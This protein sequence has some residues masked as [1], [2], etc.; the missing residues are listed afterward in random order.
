VRA[1]LLVLAIAACG[2]HRGAP[3][4]RGIRL[5]H[6]FGARESELLGGTL[7]GWPVPVSTSLVPFARGQTV[8]GALLR[9]G[10]DCPDLIRVDATWLPALVRAELVAPAPPEAARRDWL[11]EARALAQ[12]G[13][14]GDPTMYGVPQ[15]VDGL[16][17]VLGPAAAA[18]RG[19][20]PATIDELV[21]YAHDA[22]AAGARW[23]LGLRVDGY[24]VVPFLRAAGADVADG[25]TGALGIDN[26]RASAAV[27]RFAS[28]FGSVAAPAPAPGQEADDEARRF[29]AGEIALLVTGPWALADAGPLDALRVW[30][31]PGAPRGGQLFVVP[32][33]AADAAR[34][35]QLAL[36]L[37]EPDVQLAWAR[38]IG[39]VPTTATAMASAPR[40]VR[41]AYA[42]LRGA[43]PLPRD[44]ATA[45]LFDDLTPA[46][47]AVVAGDASAD[48]A[49]AGVAR[50]WKRLLAG[51]RT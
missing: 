3:P 34:A 28:L 43:K 19:P 5:L 49:L 17:V 44:P 29:Q 18:L 36:H 12:A 50:A 22:Q 31:M 40:V 48:E 21:R 16:V 41:E 7:A 10:T 8:I 4:E 6:T 32:R 1:L 46:V 39:T 27:A 30:P 38:A 15:T 42:A 23:G 35:W 26:D 14:A 37:T 20:P 51:A 11:P 9:A 24:W 25:S 2:G 33:C 13:P 45:L 47:A